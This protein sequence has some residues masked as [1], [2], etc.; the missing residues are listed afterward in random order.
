HIGL[1]QGYTCMFQRYFQEELNRLRDLGAEFSRHHPALAPMLSSSSADPDVERLLEGV[2]FLTGM[3]REKLDDEFPE[4]VHELTNIIWPHY[5]RPT[6]AS[7]IVAFTPKPMLKEPTSVPPGTSIASVPVE[8]TPCRFQTCYQVDVHPLHLV[9][10]SWKQPSGKTGYI[11]LVFELK[12]M[13]LSAWSP[14]NLRLFLQGEYYEATQLF[15]VLQRYVRRILLEADGEKTCVLKANRLRPVGF[16]PS[17]A[18]LPYPAQSFPGYRL[19]QEYFMLPEKFLFLD[20][21]GWDEWTRTTAGN[22]F[23]VRF[24]LQT[25]PFSPL[26]VNADNFVLFATPAINVFSMEG[27]PIRLD[28]RQTQYPVRAQASNPEHFQVYSIDKVVGII[29]GTAEQRTYA[30]FDLFHPQPKNTPIYQVVRQP[31]PIHRG[32]STSISVAYPPQ[33]APPRMETLSLVLQCTNGALPENLQLGDISV[34][35]ADAPEFLDFTNITLVK[36]GTHPPRRH[37]LLWRFLSHLSLNYLSLARTEN[38]KAL[39]D[40][41]LFPETRAQKS[42]LANR[43]RLDGIEDVAL[44]HVTMLVQGCMMRG[45]SIKLSLR[46]DHFAGM[47]DLFVFGSVMERFLGNY[48]SMN[49]F[50]RLWVEETTSGEELLWPARVGDR[51]L[52]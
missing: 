47:G 43:K 33:S 52:L 32:L 51:P 23:S 13:Q 8:G 42:Y 2:A 20:L 19:L 7:T 5:L 46:Q 1:R 38:L 25:P 50:T 22:R 12:G 6:P 35:T 17:T 14:K 24:E 37:N 16:D 26:R 21:F 4:I 36:P 40:L 9:H 3:L 28:H 41:Y 31:S 45:L 27:E 11:E 30:P 34:P 18:I 44:D 48:A 29:Q 15:F 39:L 49:T 10:A